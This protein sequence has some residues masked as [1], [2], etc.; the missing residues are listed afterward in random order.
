LW[1]TVLVCVVPGVF[2]QNTGYEQFGFRFALDYMV[3]LVMLLAVGRHPIT[4][5][6][7]ASVVFGALVNLFGAVTFKRFQQFYTNRFFP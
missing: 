1:T 6:F 7:K 4:R 3:Y 2:Y 5:G